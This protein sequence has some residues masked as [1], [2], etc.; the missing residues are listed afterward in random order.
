MLGIAKANAV[1]IYLLQKTFD[2]IHWE[3]MLNVV[4]NYRIPEK[5]IMQYNTK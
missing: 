1:E 2:C 3:S 4:A 5:S